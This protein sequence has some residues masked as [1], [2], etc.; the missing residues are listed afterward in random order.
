MEDDLKIA[1]PPSSPLLGTPVKGVEV[2]HLKLELKSSQLSKT[3]SGRSSSSSPGRSSSLSG[4]CM[5]EEEHQEH[6]KKEE[7]ED[8]PVGARAGSI[9]WQG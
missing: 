6:W 2:K 5:E 1:A 9:P 7:K 3:L 8:V 4:R